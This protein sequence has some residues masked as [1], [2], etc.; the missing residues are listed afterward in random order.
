MRSGLSTTNAR[1]KICGEHDVVAQGEHTRLIC[2]RLSSAIRVIGMVIADLQFNR[3]VGKPDESMPRKFCAASTPE[4][5]V[6]GL[7][8]KSYKE[9]KQQ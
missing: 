9:G 7:L 8:K 6:D 5:T 3:K 4:T 1:E 2:F